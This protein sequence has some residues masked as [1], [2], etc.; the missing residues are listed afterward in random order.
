MYRE[1]FMHNNA[2]LVQHLGKYVLFHLH[3]TGY[4]HYK[5]VL[6]IPGIA[7]LEM[8][9][10]SIGP[11][12]VELVPVFREILER[13]RLI[14]HVGAGFELLPQVLRKLPTEGLFVSVPDKYIRND[15]EFIEFTRMIW[16]G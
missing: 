12:I 15:Q 1:I 6:D 2:E 8:G 3:T 10:E 7:G 16:K 5:H 11:T 14:L 9:M 4:R 13:S